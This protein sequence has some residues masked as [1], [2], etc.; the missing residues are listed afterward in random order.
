MTLCDVP[1]GFGWG[2]YDCVLD[3]CTLR[4]GMASPY[5]RMTTMNYYDWL[6]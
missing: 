3:A 1:S 5:V 2:E 4:G 6:V